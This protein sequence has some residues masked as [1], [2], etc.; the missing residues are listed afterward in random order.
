MDV[1]KRRM[2]QDGGVVGPQQPNQSKVLSR[3]VEDIGYRNPYQ[4][5][6][7][8]EQDGNLFFERI[9]DR[10]GRLK[11]ERYID[12]NLS[13]TG[14]I[15]EALE[16]QKTNELVESAV[17]TAPYLLGGG[18]GG[19]GFKKALGTTVGKQFMKGAGD[20]LSKT[21][22]FLAP[23]KLNPKFV[24]GQ[25]GKSKLL[26]RGATENFPPQSLSQ[27]QIK[28][29]TSA[30]YGVPGAA[31]AVD[32]LVDA[33]T[34]TPEEVQEQFE[35]QVLDSDMSELEK[36]RAIES[37]KAQKDPVAYAQSIAD[38]DADL[39]AILEETAKEADPDKDPDEDT[40]D[41][42]DNEQGNDSGNEQGDGGVAAAQTTA[43][44]LSNFFSSSAFNDALRNIGGSLVK[45]GRFGAGLAGGS[46]SFA[47]EQEAKSLLQQERMAKLMEAQAASGLSVSDKLSIDKAVNEKQ[48]E[49]ADNVKD[50]NNALAGYNLATQVLDFAKSNE[51]LATFGAKFGAFGNRLLAQAGLKK[52]SDID[53]MEDTERAQVALKIL[54]NANIK[55]IL[56]ESGRTISNIDR[57]IAK[58]V[59]GDLEDFT[60]LNTL[61]DIKMKLEE[62]LNNI[63]QK[64]NLAQ[65]QIRSNVGFLLEYTPNLFET[66]PE[67]LEIIQKDF[68]LKS[69]KPTASEVG[70]I[71]PRVVKTTLRD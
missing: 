41:D 36:M 70:A 46:A 67:V 2:F 19:L 37:A 7:Q 43:N 52:I 14:D 47:D 49:L 50:Y 35:Q 60:K 26:E 48:L 66:D 57:E 4:E 62:N 53:D 5:I 51:D 32:P 55:E 22:N 25:D 9:Y 59:V 40:G 28:P 44:S 68:G 33:L 23:Y 17:E 13:A 12:R 63:T 18:L 30:A 29:F 16:R 8:I 38:F 21:I 3:R 71:Q 24:R 39:D 15:Q 31:A 61:A 45:E 34:T 11:R 6:I 10:N 56:G 58:S 64:G 20:T 42:L 54:T 1:L 27:I 65:R 69:E